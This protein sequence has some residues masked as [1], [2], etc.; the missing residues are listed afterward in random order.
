MRGRTA[1]THFL[2]SL[3]SNFWKSGS[4]CFGSLEQITPPLHK[5]SGFLS[6]DRWVGE[7]RVEEAIVSRWPTLVRGFQV[8]HRLFQR[9]A[10]TAWATTLVL[11][12]SG[13]F[14]AKR[15][16]IQF[17]L[18]VLSVHSVILH[19]LLSWA[20]SAFVKVSLGFLTTF[21]LFTQN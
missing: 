16:L 9:V 1:N 14:K 7:T 17:A 11:K 12:W 6:Q 21:P 19:V 13:F 4:L 20:V 10:G 15:A 5:H 18:W 8:R 2:K 3:Q